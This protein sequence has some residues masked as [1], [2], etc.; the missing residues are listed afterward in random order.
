M[1]SSAGLAHSLPNASQDADEAARIAEAAQPARITVATNM[2][3]RGTDIGVRGK[4]R[5]VVTTDSEHS[6]PLAPNLLQWEF[7]AE[8]PI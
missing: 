2:A 7:T 8:A 3:G 4:H 5:F 6:V 1:L